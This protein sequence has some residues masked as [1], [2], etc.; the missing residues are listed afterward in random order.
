MGVAGAGESL[1][2]HRWF[3]GVTSHDAGCYAALVLIEHATEPQTA[4]EIGTALLGAVQTTWRPTF[5]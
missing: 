5:A 2:P 3:L 4:A 1:P